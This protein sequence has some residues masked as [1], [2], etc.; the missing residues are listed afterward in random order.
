MPRPAV[1]PALVVVAGVVTAG[2]QDTAYLGIQIE[3]AGSETRSAVLVSEVDAGGP[4]A[5]A[6]LA[7]NDVVVSFDESGINSVSKLRSDLAALALGSTVTV[8]VFRGSTNQV[9]SY[10][11][12]LLSDADNVPTS[13][14]IQI[15]TSAGSAGAEVVSVTDDSAADEAGLLVGD[16]I[17]KFGNTAIAN[18]DQFRKA[19][20][21]TSQ[22]D[23]VTV[24]FTRGG[25]T[26]ETTEVT[27]RFDVVSRLP[28]V[29]MSVQD[30]SSDLAESLGYPALGGVMVISS[31]IDGPAFDAGI[32]P[33]DI[34]FLYDGQQIET[35]SEMV[36]AVRNRGGSGTVEVGYE[37]G[38]DI[39]TATVTLRGSVSGTNYALN[40]GLGLVPTVG[41]LEVVEIAS[42]SAGESAA[43]EV[44]DI[45]TAADG[46]AVATT[47]EFYEVLDAALDRTPA[48]NGVSLTTI[49]EGVTV[50]R[51]LTIRSSS[52]D[53][54]DGGDG[55]GETAKAIHIE[56]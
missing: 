1:L 21:T 43:L 17:T 12:T 55:G 33:R 51:F 19:L 10:D 35:V 11:V 36:T 5:T 14:G 8:R 56:T 13:L 28:L 18:V 37:R 39:L 54:G 20:A 41:G 42:G 24:T 9:E 6:G 53:D 27:I 15:K 47:Q 32:M 52:P 22:N 3:A 34:I 4:A 30:L 29:G 50:S 45:I 23:N 25:T 31:L 46:Q 40:V 7:A 48:V 26:G 16:I 44:D 2:C 49:R 38:G